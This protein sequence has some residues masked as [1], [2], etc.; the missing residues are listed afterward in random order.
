MLRAFSANLEQQSVEIRLSRTPS[1]S[2]DMSETL[3]PGISIASFSEGYRK[4]F[5]VV[6]ATNDQLKWHNYHLRHEVYARELGWEPLRDDEIETDAHDRH[7]VHC[8]MRAVASHMFVGC[9]RLVRADPRNPDA[10]LPFETACADHLDRKVI[11]PTRLDRARIAEISRLAVIGQYRRRPGEAGS[12]F[13]IN[14]DFGIAPRIRLPYLTLGLYLA[15]IALARWHKIDT[16]FVL[17]EPTLAHRIA[18]LGIEMRSIGTPVEHRG[19]RVPTMLQV[20]QV[21]A[22][23]A[24]YIRP[25]FDTIGD[26][27]ERA[28]RSVT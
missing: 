21:V 7:A 23:L 28:M 16:L 11:D 27:I 25:F 13:T 24:P 4:F 1:L 26:E 8:L 22:N 3:P 14:D 20:N 10:P 18:Q 5:E 17:A 2:R 6:P 15:L 9:A 12:A 19:Q